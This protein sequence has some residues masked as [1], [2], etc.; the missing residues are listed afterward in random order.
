MSYLEEDK[1]KRD[2]IVKSELSEVINYLYDNVSYYRTKMDG[3]VNSVLNDDVKLMED[4]I[5]NVSGL[6]KDVLEKELNRM[7]S[8]RGKDLMKK[9]SMLFS[10]TVLVKS[11]IKKKK[12]N[13][14]DKKKKKK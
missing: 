4:D 14:D 10:D 6:S 3:K 1:L 2:L 5:K 13:K 9:Y 12:V 8:E 7:K 11:N